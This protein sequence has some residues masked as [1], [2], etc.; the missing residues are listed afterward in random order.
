M[1]GINMD[2]VIAVIQPIRP[3][4]IAIVVVLVLGIIVTMA[5]AT[6]HELTQLNTAPDGVRL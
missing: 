1:L 3:Q 4:L 5:T 2:D 6:K